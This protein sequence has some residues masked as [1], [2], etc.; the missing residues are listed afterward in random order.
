MT[1][2]QTPHDP[3]RHANGADGPYWTALAA[4]RLELPRCTGCGLWHW[5][6]VWR[7]GACGCWDQ[8]WHLV[9]MTGTV[10]SWTR[11]WHAFGGAE[12]IGVP[13]VSVIVELPQVGGLRVLGI[14]AGDESELRIGANLAG[15]ASYTQI[16]EDR[17]P[18]LLWRLLRS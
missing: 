7:C 18:S 12:G 15:E 17:I 5:P 9:E 10:F 8:A 13:Y 11:T 4:G 1:S 14:L 16:D 3:S 6:A 2:N